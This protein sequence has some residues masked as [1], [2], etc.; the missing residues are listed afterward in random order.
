VI[1]AVSPATLDPPTWISVVAWFSLAASL[2]CAAIVAIHIARGHRQH[3]WIMNVVWPVTALYAGPLGLWAYFRWGRLSTHHAMQQAQRRGTVPPAQQKPHWQTVATA[4]TH[5]GSGCTLG[6]LA[7]EWFLVLV[8]LTLFGRPIFAAWALDYALAFLFGI[9]FQYFTIKPL[10]KLS[11]AEGVRA[12]LK[13]DALSLSAWQLGMYGWMA[14]VVFGLVG[15]EL[16]K[17]SPV[18]WFTMQLAM[19]AG[20]ATSYPVNAWLLRRGIKERM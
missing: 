2:V 14:V 13:A 6:D 4:T 5:C 11:I 7:A 19:L 17:T 20:F 1:A 15:R 18:F 3:M 10:K 12:A 16:P 8:P 9:A